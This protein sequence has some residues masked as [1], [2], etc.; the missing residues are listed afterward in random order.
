[1]K[2]VECDVEGEDP[3]PKNDTVFELLDR[4]KFLDLLHN[5]QIA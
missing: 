5:R 2:W 3:K 4:E 1:M